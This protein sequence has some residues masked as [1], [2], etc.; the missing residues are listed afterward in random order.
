VRE[1][2]NRIRSAGE[3]ALAK[4]GANLSA[5]EQGAYDHTAS[6]SARVSDAVEAMRQATL[7][8]SGTCLTPRTRACATGCM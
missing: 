7:C 8:A 2:Y 3:A 5:E 1:A 6:E 4:K